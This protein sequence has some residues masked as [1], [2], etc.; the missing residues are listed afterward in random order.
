MPCCTLHC[1]SQRVYTASAHLYWKFNVLKMPLPLNTI[2]IL[3]IFHIASPMWCASTHIPTWIS[4]PSPCTYAGF[5][6]KTEMRT[7]HLGCFMWKSHFPALLHV[8]GLGANFL[9]CK[10]K[11]QSNGIFDNKQAPA[12]FGLPQLQFVFCAF[13]CTKG[14]RL[15][16]VKCNHKTSF[17]KQN[18]CCMK[19]LRNVPGLTLSLW[20]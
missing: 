6:I 4:K 9:V 13:R 19:E 17:L 18:C 1:G 15:S 2:H 5:S 14:Q 10:E 3:Y 12:S 16:S 8:P 7:L 20:E 11:K